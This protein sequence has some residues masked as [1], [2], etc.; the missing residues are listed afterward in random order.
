MQPVEAGVMSFLSPCFFWNAYST[1]TWRALFRPLNPYQHLWRAGNGTPQEFFGVILARKWSHSTVRFYTLLQL[2][3]QQLWLGS[4][5]PA[6]PH[7]YCHC[8]WNSQCHDQGFGHIWPEGPGQA[9]QLCITLQHC[10]ISSPVLGNSF[11][12]SW[13]GLCA[14][15]PRRER[16]RLPGAAVEFCAFIS[17]INKHKATK[18]ICI[19]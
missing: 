7:S 17:S 9:F 14:W 4:S 12:L 10:K 11:K 2:L 19:V 16:N 5:I 6:L 15:H 18:E 3:E 1:N 8:C 13:N